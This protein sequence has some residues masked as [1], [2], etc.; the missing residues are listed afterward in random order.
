[1]TVQDAGQGLVY[2]R[3]MSRTAMPLKGSE[4]GR[5]YWSWWVMPPLQLPRSTGLSTPRTAQNAQLVAILTSAFIAIGT[6][7]TAYFGMRAASNTAQRAVEK[8]NHPPGTS[9]PAPPAKP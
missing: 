3:R 7:T 8:P 6:M 5:V 4:R 2:Q 1:M 9:P